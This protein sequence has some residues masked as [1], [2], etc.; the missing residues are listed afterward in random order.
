MNLT[1]NIFTFIILYIFTFE[2]YAQNFSQ[3]I[4]GTVIDKDTRS[5]L[6]GANVVL[7][8]SNPVKGTTTDINGYFRLDNVAIG[9]QNLKFSFIGYDDFFATELD[10]IS[11][12]EIVLTIEM[13][14]KIIT[15]KEVVISGTQ[16]KGNTINELSTV[17]ARTFSVEETSKYAGSWGDPS[18][19]ASN[20]AGV[21]IVSDKRNDIIVRGNSPIGV[22]WRMDGIEIPNPNHFAVAGSSGGAISMVNNNLLDNSD[23]MTS[24]FASEY[25]NALSAVFD[26]RMRNGNNEKRE[27]FAQV[28]VNG[29]ELGTE[30]PFSKKSK[31]SY[32]ISYR[33]STVAVL[34]KIG[35][36][37]IDAVPK[38]QDLSFK[39]NFPFKKN[40]ISIFG[41]GG[42]SVAKF[43]PEKDSL[44]W[45]NSNDQSGYEVGS[46]MGLTGISFMHLLTSKTLIK[47]MYEFSYSNP[48]NKNDSTGFDYTIYEIFKSSSSESNHIVSA[49]L[50]SKLNSRNLIRVGCIL[51]NTG[52]ND[53]SY[54]YQYFPIKTKNV[55]N[56]FSGNL[57]LFQSY[58][59]WKYNVTSTLSVIAG[60]HFMYLFLN[61]SKSI[62][63]RCA[64]KLIVAS[65]H[66]FSL[67]FGLYS[68][69]QPAPVYFAQVYDTANTNFTTPNKK[70]GF[71]KAYHY[72][73]GYDWMI[74]E[75]LRYK[76][77]AYIQQIFDVPVSTVSPTLSLVNFGTDDN[78]FTQS[79]YE[80]KST[81]RNYGIESTFEKFFSKNYYF[82]FTA[83][84]F[85]STYIDGNGIKRNTRYNCRYA[86]NFLAGKEFKSGRK[87]NNIIGINMMCIDIGGQHFTPINLEASKIAGQTVYTDS[88]AY[89][90]HFKD[91]FKIDIRLR[92]RINSKHISQEIAFEINNLLNRRNIET[93]YY[94]SSLKNI[95]Y[96]YQLERLPIASYRIEF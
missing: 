90:E 20:F 8:N 38:F 4:R 94:D 72:V 69:V 28:G 71:T 73:F 54:T 57:A 81:G 87:K 77:E 75:N 10:V 5:T 7:L 76:F 27:Y 96:T 79:K 14:E 63:P 24:A 85:N 56:T 67:G 16:S 37:I 66:T 83:S 80:N 50:N 33:Y 68:Q 32:L 48:F 26:L 88:L 36:S 64:L 15:G 22:L 93:Q 59:Q 23:F 82:L 31:A 53:E 18:R 91:F 34:D 89:T 40:N 17:S 45:Q 62:E 86:Y 6:T 74:R 84:L 35:I 61:N 46:Q 58:F 3:N 39:L 95:H 52:I 65:R 1:K 92:Y 29:F 49:L 78:I 9:R 13:T 44:Q 41:I 55:I 19:M 60:S 42:K 70:L 11:G 30:G 51:K 47:L 2:N 21:T 43:E 12:K 25:G